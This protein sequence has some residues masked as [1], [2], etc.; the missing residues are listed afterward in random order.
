MGYQMAKCALNQQ[1]KMIA[2]AFKDA[3]NKMILIVVEPGCIATRL[4]GWK[5]DTD[6]ET[7]ANGMVDVIENAEQKDSGL[8]I[9]CT[10][11]RILS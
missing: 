6:M 8:L 9:P 11:D 2:Q 1:T 5:C 4:T 7:S 3:E 10:G